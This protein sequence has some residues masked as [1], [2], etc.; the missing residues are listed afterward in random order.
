MAIIIIIYQRA[1][2][3]QLL[4]GKISIEMPAEVGE[5]D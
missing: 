1:S 5:G 3:S 4:K 2:V